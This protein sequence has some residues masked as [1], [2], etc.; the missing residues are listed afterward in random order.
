MRI[1]VL[2]CPALL[3]LS[4]LFSVG[5]SAAEESVWTELPELPP[6]PGQETQIGLAGPFAGVHNGALIVAGGANFP[7]APP[8]EG[9]KKVW[10]DDV[11]VLTRGEDGA[12]A[13]QPGGEPR[14]AL[15]SKLAYGVSINTA[16]GV[17]CIGGCDG[18][19]NCRQDV[20]LLKWNP[21]AK[22]VEIE[23]MPPLPG[24]LA[25][26]GGARVGDV[27]YVAGGQDKMADASATKRFLALDWS[28]K[29]DP[30]AFKWQELP[31]WPGPARV[32]PVAASQSNGSAD[33]LY[34]FSGRDFGPGRDT[35]PLTDAYSFNPQTAVWQR[36]EDVAVDGEKR[37]VTAGVAFREGANRIQVVGGD[38]MKSF[39]A[40]EAQG[41]QIATM[42]DKAAA[43]ALQQ[44]LNQSLAEH[45]G[46]SK[47]ILCYDTAANAWS[48]S[49]EFPTTSHVTTVA[50]EWDGAVVVPSGEI[51]P[52]VRTPK[53]W[54]GARK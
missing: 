26:M 8:W 19:G 37:S 48:K 3:I 49:G 11:F 30:A 34:L 29:G 44:Q 35:V 51:R 2:A 53:V 13:W 54:L 46:F 31:A 10:W 39:M 24:P 23:Q 18:D 42:E 40:R 50:V 32:L 20:F 33:C 5:S 43:D 41:K 15:P 17:L 22:A 45:A 9:G 36:L 47:D 28:K 52:G 25:F 38:D 16:E 4:V 6:N 14:W 12:Y 27:I 1:G 7:E 21:E